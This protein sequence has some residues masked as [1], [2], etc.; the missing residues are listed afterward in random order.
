MGYVFLEVYTI[1]LACLTHCEEHTRFF[2]PILT[3]EGYGIL[4]VH[5]KR[6]EARSAMLSKLR[7]NIIV[8]RSS[9]TLGI[10]LVRASVVLLFFIAPF[11]PVFT[12]MLLAQGI[13]RVGLLSISFL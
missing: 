5:H 12:T 8:S 9:S 4:S 13:A 1:L 3:S 11:L 2:N 7:D 10:V 6:S